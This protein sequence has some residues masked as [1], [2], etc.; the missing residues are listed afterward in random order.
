M[1]SVPLS[2]VLEMAEA[3][4]NF[5]IGIINKGGYLTVQDQPLIANVLFSPNMTFFAPNTAEALASFTN[6]T[7]AMSQAEL[8]AVFNY[9]I[10]PGFVA[11]SSLLE[12]G[13]K[14]QTVQGDYLTITIV[15][16]DTFVNGA[17]IINPDFL[18][19]NG[20]VHLIDS[21]LDRFNTSLPNINTSTNST[22]T[23]TL[24]AKHSQNT[25]AK[26][27]IGVSVALALIFLG[28]FIYFLIRFLKQ[29]K[30]FEDHQ[31]GLPESERAPIEGSGIMRFL[32]ARTMSNRM[33]GIRNRSYV[34]QI[35]SRGKANQA[36]NQDFELDANQVSNKRFEAVNAVELDATHT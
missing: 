14:L 21:V 7:A 18:V 36:L 31:R 11:Y 5:F 29:K 15:G 22:A 8:A 26:V 25:T 6:T 30:A 4:W 35:D 3:H 34:R 13:M 33:S 17:K 24:G 10:V 28:T 2:L 20:V 19:A 12:S 1:L 9:H 27:G 32:R 23:Q 16:S